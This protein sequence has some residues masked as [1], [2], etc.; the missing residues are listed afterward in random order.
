MAYTVRQKHFD[1]Q[2]IK[3]NFEILVNSKE[4][5]INDKKQILHFL[6]ELT[7]SKPTEASSLGVVKSPE[8]P[9]IAE[10]EINIPSMNFNGFKSQINKNFNSE[11]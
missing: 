11:K 2:I 8:N 7:N 5:D 10:S 1:N 4:Y 6:Y 9:Q 3:K